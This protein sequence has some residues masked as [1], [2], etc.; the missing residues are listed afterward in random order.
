MCCLKQITELNPGNYAEGKCTEMLASS[1]FAQKMWQQNLAISNA[2][3]KF[4]FSCSNRFFYKK[5]LFYFQL[6]SRKD[7]WSA[8]AW[9]VFTNKDDENRILMFYQLDRERLYLFIYR[10]TDCSPFLTHQIGQPSPF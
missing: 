2:S 4:V 10:N 9:I 6:F 1:S 5:F 7:L 8:T 3:V